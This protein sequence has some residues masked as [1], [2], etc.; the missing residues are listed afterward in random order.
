MDE[1]DDVGLGVT[2]SVEVGGSLHGEGM[3]WKVVRMDGEEGGWV[4]RRVEGGAGGCVHIDEED[5]VGLGV[6]MSVEVGDSLHG[7]GM[8]WKVVRMDGEEGG[9]V[10]RRVEGGV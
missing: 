7:E 4:I 8:G 3:G 6:T 5:D 9:W 10:V 2:I 1:E